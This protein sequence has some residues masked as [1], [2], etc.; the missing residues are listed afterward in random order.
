MTKKEE[1]NLKNDN[2]R[3]LY[4]FYGIKKNND[5][6]YIY[7]KRDGSGQCR[8]IAKIIVNELVIGDEAPM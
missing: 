4:A 7:T 6:I 2:C 1:M 5:N 3:F 8:V